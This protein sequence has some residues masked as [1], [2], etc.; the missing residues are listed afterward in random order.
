MSPIPLPEDFDTIEAWSGG[1]TLSPGTHVVKCIS[2]DDTR[3]SSGGHNQIELELEAVDGEEVGATI[4][5]WQI[6][7]TKSWGKVKQLWEAFGAPK[8]EGQLD[9]KALVG[10]TAKIIVRT[11]MKPDGSDVNRVKAYQ[12]ADAVSRVKEA[13][14]GATETKADDSIP[15]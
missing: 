13:F 4:R 2:T 7:T 12:A 1:V 3:T 14:P 5:D 8:P 15:F 9:A 10:K 6:V 11:E